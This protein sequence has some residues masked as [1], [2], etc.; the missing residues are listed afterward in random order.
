[1]QDTNLDRIST[2]ELEEVEVYGPE[3]TQNA[4]LD[5]DAW[6]VSISDAPIGFPLSLVY[7]ELGIRNDSK[8]FDGYELWFVPHRVALNR[9]KGSAEVVR[10]GLEVEYQNGKKTCSVISLFPAPEFTTHGSVGTAFQGTLNAS[11]VAEKLTSTVL[12][13]TNFAFAKDAF[14]FGKSTGASLNF[15]F[16]A[17]VS[18]PKISAVGLGSRHAAWDMKKDKDPLFGRDIETWSLLALPR[19]QTKLSYRLRFYV[20]LRTVFIPTWRE[21]GWTDVECTLSR[22]GLST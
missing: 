2:P 9:R 3:S 22:G 5:P 6:Y 1:M 4:G 18:T 14:Q 13:Q 10:F 17:T 11:G 8:L 7:H 21:S 12:E 20:T 16:N 19:F 15:N